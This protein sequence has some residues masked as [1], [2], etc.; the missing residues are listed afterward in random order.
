ME[1][2][3]VINGAEAQARDRLLDAAEE[4]FCEN[5][6]DKTS[7]RELTAAARCNIAA[8]NYHFGSKGRLY[9]EMFRRQMQRMLEKNK[10][11][12]EQVLSR[13][14]VTLEDFIR[15]LV[16][17]HF[18]AMEASDSKLAVMKLMV[19]EVLNQ[20]IA[21]DE[22]LGDMMGEFFGMIAEGFRRFCPELGAR[23]MQMLIFGLDALVI[24]PVLFFDMYQEVVPDLT[25][26]DVIEH[27]V[28]FASAGIRWRAKGDH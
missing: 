27:T 26:D 4:L 23:D 20:H 9:I 6:F 12:I 25:I 5:G 1:Q 24:H 21:K 10:R 19:R 15:A 3:Q 7:V 11:I 8:V 17:E 14:D 18:R 22:I 28:R 16:S 13:E 2:Q